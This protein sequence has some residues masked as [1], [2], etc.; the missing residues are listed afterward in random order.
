MRT[1][2]P[3]TVPAADWR[4][5]VLPGVAAAWVSWRASWAVA[6]G[7]SRASHWPGGC[8]QLQVVYAAVTRAAVRAAAASL[9]GLTGSRAAGLRPLATAQLARQLT[10]AAATPGS[11]RARESVA[12]T[13]T[14][15]Q[16]RMLA[17][18][19]IIIT[20]Q[21]RQVTTSPSGTTRAVTALAIT[22]VPDGRNGWAVYDAEPASAGDAGG[23]PGAAP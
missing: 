17:P 8:C 19:T 23:V 5:R 3:V 9:G 13:V 12:G 14:G 2:S 11:T 20:V 16:V 10:Q 22:L 7:R 18:G 6:S 1:C 15:E 21:V 4:A